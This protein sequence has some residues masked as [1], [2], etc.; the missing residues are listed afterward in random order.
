MDLDSWQP[1]P[2]AR[3]AAEANGTSPAELTVIGKAGKEPAGSAVQPIRPILD[4]DG[5]EAGDGI[6]RPRL[7]RLT[8]F[9]VAG[10]DAVTIAGAMVLAH[11]ML[12]PPDVDVALVG[13]AAY[14]RLG[15][16][17][18]PLWI[19][20]FR[21]YRLYNARHVTGRRDEVGHLVHAVAASTLITTVVAYFLDVAVEKSWFLMLFGVAVAAMLVERELIRHGF[22]TLRRRGRC[23]RPVAVAGA[24]PE[25]LAMTR[26]F[27]ERP[28]LGYSVVG[29]VGDPERVAPGLVGR[30]PVFGPGSRVVEELRTVGA[31]GVVVATTDVD[32]ETSNR[33]IRTLTDAGIHV[34]LSSSL[35][36]IDATRLSVRPLGGFS[37]L[38]VEPVKRNGWRPV[39]KRAFDIALSTVML[40]VVLPVL[41]VAAL[42]IK[43][44]SPGPIFFAQERIGHRGRVFKILKLRTMWVDN[45]KL[46]LDAALEASEGL[47]KLR[48]DPR[49]TPVGRLLR[50]LSVDELPQLVNVL[51]G[52][53]SL[54][55]PR[56]QLLS[57]VALWTPDVFERLRVCPGVTGMWQVSGRSQ[58]REAKDRWDL[59]Y[60]DNWSVWRDLTILLKT[61]PAVI[62]SKGAY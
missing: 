57:E 51:I 43:L 56:P 24:G 25:A 35:R 44:T 60:V 5:R 38:Y 22:N 9:F 59:Y 18:L 16:L 61:V 6:R 4:A 1:E 33:L 40:I 15:L 30:Y 34:E 32:A 55:G 58:D 49:V 14:Q 46:L 31:S 20:V 12:P 62:S 13:S 2:A 54:V 7:V 26:A 41:A 19:E 36:D 42:A 17:S 53:M 11:A 48:R 8:R 39:A 3:S 52:Q 50:R 10:A 47:V 37:M 21:R 29:L 27:E 28:E 45:D 23:L